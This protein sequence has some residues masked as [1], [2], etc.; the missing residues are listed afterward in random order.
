MRWASH[1]GM[2]RSGPVTASPG[3]TRASAARTRGWERS[4]S[5]EEALPIVPDFL[6]LTI[7]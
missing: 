6:A 1:V 3:L 7:E 5:M 2:P 4:A